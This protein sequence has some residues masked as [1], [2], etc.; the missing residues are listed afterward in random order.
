MFWPTTFVSS[1]DV[2]QTG[3]EER[4][5]AQYDKSMIVLKLGWRAG[6]CPCP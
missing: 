3:T 4:G 2:L 1:A 5:V 6:T